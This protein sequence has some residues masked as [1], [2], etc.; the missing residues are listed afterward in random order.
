MV[1]RVVCVGLLIGGKLFKGEYGCVG[2]IGV[3]CIGYDWVFF[4]EVFGMFI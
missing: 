3:M 4:D 2:N 1:G